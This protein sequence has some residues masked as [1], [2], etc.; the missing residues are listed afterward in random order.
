MVVLSRIY[1]AFQGRYVLLRIHFHALAILAKPS[2]YNLPTE[3]LLDKSYQHGFM[4]RCGS[5]ISSQLAHSS[6]L[7]A[8][9]RPPS[10]LA[11]F[12]MNCYA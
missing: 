2:Y 8:Y 9:F 3:L 5:R 6:S 7:M 11:S 12:V 10:P 4:A 1:V